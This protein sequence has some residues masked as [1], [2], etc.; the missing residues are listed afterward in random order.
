[1]KKLLC[2]LLI[3]LLAGCA[4]S[5]KTETV[6]LMQYADPDTSGLFVTFYDGHNGCHKSMFED[7]AR[8][9]LIAAFQNAEAELL[10]DFDPATMT[11]P[12]YGVE[13]GGG[14]LG[15]VYGLWSDGVFL[16][17]FGEAYAFDYDFEALLEHP[18]WQESGTYALTSFLQMPCA[19]YVVKGTDGWRSELLPLSGVEEAPEGIAMTLVEMEGKTITVLLSNQSGEEWYYGEYYHLEVQL[20]GSW[21]Q[22]PTDS[23]LEWGFHDI[24]MILPDGKTAEQTYN[25]EMYGTLPDG[26]YRLAAENLTVEFR[27]E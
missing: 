19:A 3:L 16:T 8:R 26:L 21:Y 7:E 15:M 9:E 20:D 11:A 13:M 6:N 1:M 2:I 10:P 18:D 24:A 22:I 25:L 17:K 27:V 14:D 23:T 5:E 12:F 4:A